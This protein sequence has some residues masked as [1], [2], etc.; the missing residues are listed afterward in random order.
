Y[1]QMLLGALWAVVEPL[2]Q[3]L[4]LTAVFGLLL[5]V[6]TG[7]LP[8]PVFAFSGLAGWWLF[9]RGTLAA[10][11]SLQENMGLISKVYFPRLILPIV[12]VCRELFDAALIV[13]LLVVLAALYGFAPSWKVLLLPAIL[14][15]A[16]LVAL[17]A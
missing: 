7:G 2:G 9:S 5:K 8:Y 17:A 4:L 11:G 3:L 6:D 13:V 14:L 1:R 12:G 15:Y 16:A 10:A